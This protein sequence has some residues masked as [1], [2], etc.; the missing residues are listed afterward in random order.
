V[1]VRC[2]R[3]LPLVLVALLSA[4][5]AGAGDIVVHTVV[6]LSTFDIASAGALD[7]FL[8]WCERH[9]IKVIVQ[10]CPL[11][12][13]VVPGVTDV[14]RRHLGGAVAAVTVRSG[15]CQPLGYLPPEFSE[16]RV[17]AYR[18]YLRAQFGDRFLEERVV[19]EP[20]GIDVNLARACRS[21]GVELVVDQHTSW[22]LWPGVDV[23]WRVLPWQVANLADR[24]VLREVRLGGL[25][26]WV[27]PEVDFMWD[28]VNGAV[29]YGGEWSL[30]AVRWLLKEA[31]LALVGSGSFGG[32]RDARLVLVVGVYEPLSGVH[33]GTG[34]TI[35]GLLEEFLTWLGSGRLDFTLPDG[36]RVR[37]VL[38][39]PRSFLD[40][41]TRIIRG[42]ARGLVLTLPGVDKT[43][44]LHSWNLKTLEELLA[45]GDPL[46]RS[47]VETWREGYRLLVELAP[48]MLEAFR[49]GDEALRALIVDIAFRTL[50]EVGLSGLIHTFERSPDAEERLKRLR[51]AL[52][53]WV[54]ELRLLRRLLDGEAVIVG[55]SPV[56]A[57]VTLHGA[58]ATVRRTVRSIAV[59]V[60]DLKG[61]ELVS[62]VLPRVSDYV[63]MGGL[64]RA[65]SAR[66]EGEPGRAFVSESVRFEGFRPGSAEVEVLDVTGARIGGRGV[67]LAELSAGVSLRVSGEPRTVVV[68]VS[69][70]SNAW[71]WTTMDVEIVQ[72]VPLLRPVPVRVIG[73]TQTPSGP[74]L[75]VELAPPL[76]GTVRIS[77]GGVTVTGAPSA[78]VV[79]PVGEHEVRAELS[80]GP[81]TERVAFRILLARTSRGYVLLTDDGKVVCADVQGRQTGAGSLRGFARLLDHR[82]DWE[83]RLAVLYAS[84]AGR[85]EVALIDPA[86]GRILGAWMVTVT[87]DGSCEAFVFS[88]GTVVTA[89]RGG[90][91]G[92]Y[93]VP[94]TPTDAREGIVAYRDAGGRVR[95]VVLAPREPIE[96]PFGTRVS[97]R[98]VAFVSRSGT[99]AVVDDR[100]RIA[101][102]GDLPECREVLDAA[103][104]C[105]LYRG[106]RGL[107][108]ALIDERGRVH[109][110]DLTSP[111]VDERGMV[112]LFR[113]GGSTVVVVASG[114]RIVGRWALTGRVRCEEGVLIVGGRVLVAT[115]SGIEPA[116]PPELLYVGERFRC[117]RRGPLL[118]IVPVPVGR[119][120]ARA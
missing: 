7:E 97:R 62:L 75:R 68:R 114:G 25:T 81:L 12:E 2:G 120:G 71:P 94:G 119:R 60:L 18:E 23:S 63:P 26:L 73:V 88:E 116:R 10:H 9:G 38:E 30:R 1:E 44:Y 109:R 108:C 54:A 8:S 42:E 28:L 91:V 27:V 19:W 37:F 113:V 84:L 40:A 69:G 110:P 55:A 118:P 61:N 43:A 6:T 76:P 79:L 20:F 5:V 16:V 13:A 95:A 32:V 77:V 101:A 64:A 74:A 89:A 104:G 83:G 41:V 47:V 107:E 115:S 46:V 65:G 100:G 4:P 70:V 39:D 99:F 92:A 21:V 53:R 49:G 111:T 48:R 22:G 50:N 93:R 103:F 15:P 106:A 35:R 34:R 31:V 11:S 90:I 78:E 87:R 58:D 82:E 67:D 14:V 117:G 56:D 72:P 57:R 85:D 17:R 105:V 45:S 80:C 51:L 98:L 59:T 86:T 36:T 96:M 29:T 66:V 3:V 52:E 112:Y 24:M 102:V 33:G